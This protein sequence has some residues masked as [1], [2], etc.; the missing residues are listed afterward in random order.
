[1]DQLAKR[2]AALR[3]ALADIRPDRMKALAAFREDKIE[4][5]INNHEFSISHLI[6]ALRKGKPGVK[7]G[8][9]YCLQQIA[10]RFFRYRCPDAELESADAW[11]KWW[12]KQ[13]AELERR[14]KR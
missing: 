2:V 11:S 10:W 9:A 5:V 12:R 3:K 7:P 4:F 14:S 6:R 8:A 1:M 13:E